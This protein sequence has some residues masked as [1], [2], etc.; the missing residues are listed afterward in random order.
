[1]PVTPSELNWTP[2]GSTAGVLET[3]RATYQSYQL[4]IEKQESHPNSYLWDA[5]LEIHDDNW[6]R[7]PGEMHL[8]SRA[9]AKAEALRLLN[10]H[11]G[12]PANGDAKENP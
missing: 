10:E 12:P 3:Y 4:V 8:L 2:V 6:M 5:R 7:S 1:V 11:L 9:E